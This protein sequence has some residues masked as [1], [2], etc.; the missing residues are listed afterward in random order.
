MENCHFGRRER[1]ID[2]CKL[3]SQT[4]QYIAEENKWTRNNADGCH[5]EKVITRCTGVAKARSHQA[6]NANRG[7]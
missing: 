6:Q 7:N 2:G 1:T 3:E 5:I 4:N